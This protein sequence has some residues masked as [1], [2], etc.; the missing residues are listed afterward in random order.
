MRQILDRDD[1]EGAGAILDEERLT[2]RLA[3]LIGEDARD[4]VGGAAWT[5][6]HQDFDRLRWISIGRLR[7]CD[8]GA[9]GRGE[10]GERAQDKGH[11]K[12][13]EKTSKLPMASFSAPRRHSILP[14]RD[15]GFPVCRLR[16]ERL[17]AG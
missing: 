16:D 4:D 2:E 10:P 14:L 3:E 1:A 13:R 11:G 9:K 6:G 15:A 12:A 5:I 8:T 17:F 7:P